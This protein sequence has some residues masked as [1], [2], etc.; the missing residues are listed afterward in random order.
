MIRR[1]V[2]VPDAT[3]GV[4]TSIDLIA[5]GG[6]VAGEVRRY[7]YWYRDSVTIVCGSTFNLNPSP[8]GATFH[9][10]NGPEIVWTL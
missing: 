4:S 1:E 9:L 3:G 8:C 5:M 10:S 2:S 7:Q 6:V